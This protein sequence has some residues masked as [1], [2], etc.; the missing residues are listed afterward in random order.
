[1]SLVEELRIIKQHKAVLDSNVENIIIQLKD[2]NLPLFDRWEAYT[3]LVR[4]GSLNRNVSFG[5][6]YVDILDEDMTLYDDF[7]V[8]RHEQRRYIDMYDHMMDAEEA[9]DEK[10]VRARQKNLVEWQETV[11][12]SGCSSFT[13]DW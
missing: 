9:F 8:E 11:L 7:C 10:M 2:T 4:T 6:G 5:D 12:Q 13:F 1:M 3:D